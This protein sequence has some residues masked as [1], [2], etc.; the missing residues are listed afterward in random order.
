MRPKNINLLQEPS[1]KLEIFPKMFRIHRSVL[2][3]IFNAS[4][5]AFSILLGSLVHSKRVQQRR[6]RLETIESAKRAFI[7]LVR[8]QIE[9]ELQNKKIVQFRTNYVR[10]R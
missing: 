6:Q 1:A 7:C 8:E 3:A 4:I 10:E 2:K 5:K 9:Y